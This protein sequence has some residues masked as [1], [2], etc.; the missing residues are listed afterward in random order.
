MGIGIMY[1]ALSL[2]F[3]ALSTI[4]NPMKRGGM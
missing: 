2:V 4:L 3:K 1:L